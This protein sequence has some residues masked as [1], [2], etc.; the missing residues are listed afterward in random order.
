M[1]TDDTVVHFASTAEP[2]P[3]GTDRMFATLGCPRFINAADRLN[4]GVVACHQLL[5]LVADTGAIPLDRF[6]QTL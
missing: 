4:V 3:C 1:H 2:L 5:A 6:H